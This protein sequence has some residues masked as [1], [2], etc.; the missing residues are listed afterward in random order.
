MFYIVFATQNPFYHISW[1]GWKPEKIYPKMAAFINAA[2][3]LA[4]KN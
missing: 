2:D 3:D 4:S 1:S